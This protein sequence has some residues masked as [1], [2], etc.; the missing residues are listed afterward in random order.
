MGVEPQEDE[1]PVDASDLI[2]EAQMALILFN[3][4]P[5]N[6]AGMEGY[7]MG[8]EYGGMSEILDIYSV[9]QEDRRLIFELL[10]VCIIEYRKYYAEKRKI[11]EAQSRINR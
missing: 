7:W 10:Q 2:Y 4:L 3:T 9:E 1:L 5:D 11:V 6:I 8:K